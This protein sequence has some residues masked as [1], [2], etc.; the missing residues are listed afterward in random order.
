MNGTILAHTERTGSQLHGKYPR[1]KFYLESV[2]FL[3]FACGVSGYLLDESLQSA[4]R[5]RYKKICCLLGNPATE[6]RK[7]LKRLITSQKGY[8]EVKGYPRIA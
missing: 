7:M 8:Q 1:S 5:E 6:L 2:I 4:W 3:E